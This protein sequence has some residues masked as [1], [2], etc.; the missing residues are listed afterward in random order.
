MT[1]IDG[2]SKEAKAA[3]ALAAQEQTGNQLDENVG[4]SNDTIAPVVVETQDLNPVVQV[5][6]QQ[7]SIASLWVAQSEKQTEDTDVTQMLLRQMQQMQEE[8]KSLKEDKGEDQNMFVKGREIFKW[9]W[10]YR[11]KLYGGIPVLS[12][13][14]KKQDITKDYIFK[15]VKGEMVSNHI[16]EVSL[17]DW[18]KVDV[19][20]IDFN[21]S[22]TS[23]EETFGTLIN[24]WGVSKY[25][26]STQEYGE[27]K[28]LASVIN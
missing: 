10:K 14:S 24:E 26:F 15:N 9:P 1:K 6:E 18:Q 5:E 28:V 21:R 16:L 12:I 3:A 25:V 23:S 2:R 7:T 19:D 17:A 13:Q 11:F 20:V 4:Q 27:I 8:I 22:V